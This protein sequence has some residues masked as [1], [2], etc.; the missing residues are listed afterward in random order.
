VDVHACAGHQPGYGGVG[1]AFKL[2]H[3][4]NR[5]GQQIGKWL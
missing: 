1:L 4:A 2:V 3:L 5:V